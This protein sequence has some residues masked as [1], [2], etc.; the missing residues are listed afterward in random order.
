MIVSLQK[1]LHKNVTHPQ[2][3]ALL[4]AMYRCDL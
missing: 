1:T 2:A 4:V 3:V